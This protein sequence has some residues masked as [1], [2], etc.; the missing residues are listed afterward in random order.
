MKLIQY[1]SSRGIYAVFQQIIPIS[2][3]E[4]YF[5]LFRGHSALKIGLHSSSFDVKLF[6]I[7]FSVA[8][9]ANPHVWRNQIYI[10]GNSQ[11][12][13]WHPDIVSWSPW[14][15]FTSQLGWK[16]SALKWA[17]NSI[18]DIFSSFL[19]LNVDEF[20]LIWMFCIHPLYLHYGMCA[21]TCLVASWILDWKGT[22]VWYWIF[23][24]IFRNFLDNFGQLVS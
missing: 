23:F 24:G 10:Q 2:S 15:Y 1:S 3:S 21:S 5:Y 19:L 11:Q 13:L 17:S 12:S 6:F 14:G 8:T 9:F 18:V 20:L 7:F 4:I 16:I 22:G